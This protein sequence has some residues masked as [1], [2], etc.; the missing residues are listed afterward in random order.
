ME[1]NIAVNISEITIAIAYMI[2]KNSFCEY[3]LSKHNIAIKDS[4]IIVTKMF[5]ANDKY[6]FVRAKFINTAIQK[7]TQNIF[8]ILSFRSSTPLK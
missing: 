7:Y 3:E 6:K 1:I 2:M 4:N 8:P 5:G